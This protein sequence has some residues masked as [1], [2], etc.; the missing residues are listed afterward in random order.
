MGPSVVS[1]LQRGSS[2]LQWGLAKRLGK[3]LLLESAHSVMEVE[4][5][6]LPGEVDML[7]LSIISSISV[8]SG[9]Q[10]AASKAA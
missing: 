8:A 4:E 5:G 6:E 3:R 9:Q 7:S 10:A 2:G 1:W